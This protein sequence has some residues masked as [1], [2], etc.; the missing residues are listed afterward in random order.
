MDEN[1]GS[2]FFKD[3]AVGEV[4]QYQDIIYQKINRYV[5]ITCLTEDLEDV[6]ILYYV[7]D[8]NTIVDIFAHA[9]VN[10]TAV[11]VEIST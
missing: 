7:I 6:N 11:N 1:F 4:F 3:L 9:E 2:K 8:T 10:D 5:A